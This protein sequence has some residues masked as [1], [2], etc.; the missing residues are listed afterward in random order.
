MPAYKVP[1]PRCANF[2]MRD[3][4]A[5][6]FCQ[7]KDPFAP[8]RCASCSAIIEDPRW[9]ACQR[10]GTPVPKP[11]APAAATGTPAATQTARP[12]K[13]S[14]PQPAAAPA[15]RFCTGCGGSLVAGARF[16]TVC[17]TIAG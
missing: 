4:A 2:I 12:A 16:C 11:G 5:C 13:E 10:C 15:G 8:M 1:C 7:A 3:A 6:P 17:G 9:A 14:T